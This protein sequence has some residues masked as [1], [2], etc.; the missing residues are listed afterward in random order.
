M[1]HSNNT[2]PLFSPRTG[3]VAAAP[4]ADDKPKAQVYANIGIETNH[5][6][7]PFM[8][9]PFG[10][11]VDTQ[12]PKQ[13]RGNDA[14]FVNFTHG[15]NELLEWLQA[16]AAKLQPGESVILTGLT[17]EL[18]RSKGDTVTPATADNPFSLS[19]LTTVVDPAATA[20][21]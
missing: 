12:Q 20:E 8:S 3:F 14:D 10:V 9:L 18:R 5:P 2:R 19:A 16:E 17:V 15:Q 4:A 13:V 21:G 7:Y 1:I 11:P 6:K